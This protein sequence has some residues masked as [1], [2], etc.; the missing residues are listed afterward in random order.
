MART[1]KSRGAVP[2]KMRSGN[3]PSPNK[4]LGA[5]TG[6][7]GRGVGGLMGN[8]GGG[9]AGGRGPG[10]MAGF[11]SA[12]QAAPGGYQPGMLAKHFGGRGIGPQGATVGGGRSAPMV[13]KETPYKRIACAR[14]SPMKAADATL[15]KAYSDA[16]RGHGQIV[17]TIKG[18]TKSITEIGTS[19]GKIF[20]KKSKRGS[21]GK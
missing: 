3:R 10:G 1:S 15:I 21:T 20:A 17:K 13:K 12:V 18:K 5:M 11:H 16:M 4:F 8:R 7:M 14:R 6:M 2:F 19:L 9:Q